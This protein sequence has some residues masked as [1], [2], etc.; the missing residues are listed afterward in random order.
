MEGPAHESMPQE[1]VTQEVFAREESGVVLTQDV[2]ARVETVATIMLLG[3]D[4]IHTDWAGPRPGDAT[5]G[6]AS[7]PVPPEGPC[8]D[9]V[10]CSPSPS[11]PRGT[12]PSIAIPSPESLGAGV[13]GLPQLKVA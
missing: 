11:L 13:A 3:A 5:R 4:G 7:A 12:A 2:L 6:N 10:V 8:M 9:M 1:M